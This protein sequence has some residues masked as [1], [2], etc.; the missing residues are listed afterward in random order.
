[1]CI[2]AFTIDSELT[3]RPEF[4]FL[5]FLPFPQLLKP[6]DQKALCHIPPRN[7][8]LSSSSSAWDRLHPHFRLHMHV[9]PPHPL[10]SQGYPLYHQLVCATD[11]IWPVSSIYKYSLGGTQPYLFIYVLSTATLMLYW[12]S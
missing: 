5:P 1:M 8:F 12:Q 6:I 4:L 2:P 9:F 3:P 7:A 10:S 11:Q